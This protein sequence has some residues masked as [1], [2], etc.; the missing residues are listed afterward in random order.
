[1]QAV[2]VS[3]YCRFWNNMKKLVLIGFLFL[4]ISCKKKQ[5]PYFSELTFTRANYKECYRMKFNSS[6]TVYCLEGCPYEKE[7]LKYMILKKYQKQII[8]NYMR[9]LKFP[10][11]DSVFSN[12]DII[13]GT[14]I[15]FS[16]KKNNS[17]NRLL[18]HG[19]RGPKLFWEFGKWIDSLKRCSNF[20]LTNKKIK[21]ERFDD[22]LP[23]LPIP[24]K[25]NSR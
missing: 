23:T 16:I 19:K 20:K 8:N 5:E 25:N 12:N 9:E 3:D 14:T 24:I 17:K 2:Y 1:M 15:C 4:M 11:K 18:L 7:V 13:D 21:F 22:M 6:D 10:S